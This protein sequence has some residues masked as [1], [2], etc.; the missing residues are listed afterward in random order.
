MNTPPPE[1]GAPLFGPDWDRMVGDPDTIRRVF[2]AIPTMV[3]ALEG[4]RHTYVAANAAYRA[5][6]PKFPGV[7]TSLLDL[8]PEVEGQAMYEAFDRVYET[9][10]PV[11][12]SEW[13]VH[14]DMDG[15]GVLQERIF[16]M[17]LTPRRDDAG[18]VIGVQVLMTNVTDRVRQRTAAQKRAEEMSG[19]FHALRDSATV[20]QR[21]LLAADLPVLPGIDLAA[22]YLVAAEDTAAGGDWFDA[23]PVP[24][25]AVL[26]VGDVVGHGVEAAAAMAQ[27]RTAVRMQVLA[28]RDITDT[29]AAVEDFVHH[30]PNGKYA[31]LCVGRLD[32]VTGAFEYCTAGHPPPLLITGSGVPRF[33]DPSGA[34]PLGSGSQWQ[35]C[36]VTLGTGDAVLLYSDG[37][38]E[39]PGRELT[40]SADEF[41]RLAAGILSGGGLPLDGLRP[42]ERLCA[43]TI[44]L[45]LRGTGYGDDVTL[46]A[47][48][49]RESPAALALDATADPHAG[50]TVRHVLRE[51]LT[52]LGVDDTDLVLLEHAVSEYVDNAAEHAYSDGEAGGLR[53]DGV[54]D[55]DGCVRVTV[56]D[57]GRWKARGARPRN[58]GRGLQMAEALVSHSNVTHDDGGTT[59]TATHRLQRP[60]RIVTDQQTAFPQP[61][62]T[63]EYAFAIAVDEP[64]TITLR[65]DIGTGDAETLAAAIASQSRAGTRPL[66]IDLRAVTHLGSSAV[67]VLAEARE[68]AQH[69]QTPFTMQ[70]SPGGAA[71][72]VLTLVRLPVEQGPGQPHG[73]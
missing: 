52:G 37:V 30:V 2:E 18:A 45:L 50:A 55:D 64:G 41:A 15:S 31:T 23:V 48:Q 36:T 1:R 25:G 44:E 21:A 60:A 3:C 63:A 29:L 72:R 73:V 19:R 10:E 53:V 12:A 14:A 7:G 38:I 13:R 6:Y 34:G 11:I 9:G 68:R 43:Q 33:L 5:E 46:L 51:W 20:M 28:G 54:L 40:A 71:H 35:A 17:V 16:D 32:A 24:G 27:L 39:R 4:P 22:E 47:A 26:V 62:T 8:A 69:N 70:V 57:T 65:G 56:S 61:R 66:W 49:R 58:R 42:V 67:A 59:A